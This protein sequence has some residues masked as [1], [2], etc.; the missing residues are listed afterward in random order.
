MTPRLL[1]RGVVRIEEIQVLVVLHRLHQ[2]VLEMNFYAEVE[3]SPTSLVYLKRR[4]CDHLDRLS[5]G[6]LVQLEFDYRDE[7]GDVLSVGASNIAAPLVCM[8]GVYLFRS[9]SQASSSYN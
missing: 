1:A 9:S 3:L 5:E 7:V 6:V 2:A 8:I 4:L